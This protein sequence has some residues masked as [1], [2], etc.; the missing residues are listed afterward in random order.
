MKK[1]IYFLAALAVAAGISSC[2][3]TKDEALVPEKTVAVDAAKMAELVAEDS[4]E[5]IWFETEVVYDNFLDE[6]KPLAVASVKSTFQ[7]NV[8]DSLGVNTFVYVFNHELGVEDVDPEPIHDFVIENKP[9][10][11]E[12]VVLTF[13]DA[14]ERVFETNTPTPHTRYV[15]LRKELG[16][17]PGVNPQY[18]FG[19]ALLYVDAV[20]GEVT[21]KNPVYP[22]EEVEAT[23]AE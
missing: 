5:Y 18:I 3:C 13:A 1:V 12:E 21:D 19:Q 11:D 8:T 7:E 2:K 20:T 22:V 14:V 10:V 4:A 15:V 17:K 23:E 6:D 9:L 16:P